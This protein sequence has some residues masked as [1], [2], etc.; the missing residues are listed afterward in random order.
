MLNE[1]QWL[2]TVRME[3]F[4]DLAIWRLFINSIFNEVAGVVNQTGAD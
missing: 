4:I 1:A 2:Y 3:M